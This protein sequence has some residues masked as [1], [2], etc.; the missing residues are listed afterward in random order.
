[1]R[2]PKPISLAKTCPQPETPNVASKSKFA[3]AWRA[4]PRCVRESTAG[5]QNSEPLR[6]CRPAHAAYLGSSADQLTLGDGDYERID[7]PVPQ[8]A[9]QH[10]PER[11]LMIDRVVGHE[12]AS[13][14]Q[15]RDDRVVATVVDLLF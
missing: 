12:Q 15:A 9:V 6:C 11:C 8:G 5:G 7:P 4:A 2:L 14:H 10:G 1:M 3:I 13:P